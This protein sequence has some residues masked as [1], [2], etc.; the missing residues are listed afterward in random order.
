MKKLMIIGSGELQVPLIKICKKNGYEVIATDRDENAKGFAYAD[1]SIVVDGTDKEKI[2]EYAIKWNIDGI[3]T[4]AEITLFTVVFVCEKLGLK[5]PSMKAAQISN[6]K[7]LMRKCMIENGIKSP[8]FWLVHN[9]D[10]LNEIENEIKFP[11]VIKPVD[12]SGSIGVMKADN[13]DEIKAI[14][15][16]ISVKSRSNRVI[17]EE[18]M[19]GPEFSVETLSMNG[20]H[21]MIAITEKKV[22]GYPYFVEERHVIP[23]NINNK[24]EKEIKDLVIRLLNA[25]K[26]DNCAGHTEV[27]LTEDGPMI[28]ET[29]ARIGGDYIA[30]DLV[31]LA[32]GISMHQSIA[33]IALGEEIS[34]EK[35]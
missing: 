25:C 7:Y 16:D 10:E 35:S 28:V 4:T 18:F 19:E 34:F 3:V 9:N 22:S 11:V 6:D 23:A 31:P 33:K 26:F 27:K 17:I 30:S 32:T 2:L 5:G 12:V 14:F 13:M 21:N 1:K 8:R 29:G 20:I 24:Q 15:D